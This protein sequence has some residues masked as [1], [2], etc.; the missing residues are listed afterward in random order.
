MKNALMIMT[1]AIAIFSN[2]CVA[3]KGTVKTY[4]NPSVNASRIEAVAIFPLRNSFVQRS[5]GLG[6]GEMID[7]NKMFQTEFYNQNKGVKMVDAVM[8]RELLNQGNMVNAYDTLLAVY[9]NTGIPNTLILNRIGLKL[10]VDAIIQGFIKEVFQRDGVYGGNRGEAKLWSSISCFLP[11]QVM[12][13]GRQPV[14]VIK[15]QPLHWP[16]P[17]RLMML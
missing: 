17:H 12:S 7:I 9:E 4:N 11:E 15:G 13:S 14:R 1:I 3:K 10:G 2:G 16:K 5:V 8:S 6:T